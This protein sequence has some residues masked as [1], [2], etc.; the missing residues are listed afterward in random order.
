M[1]LTEARITTK[2]TARNTIMNRALKSFS[3]SRPLSKACGAIPSTKYMTTASMD[4]PTPASDT[5]ARNLLS[6]SS[7]F[8]AGSASANRATI[9]SGYNAV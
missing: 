2:A 3:T 9:I 7:R 8:T 5:A 6:F 4:R 1:N